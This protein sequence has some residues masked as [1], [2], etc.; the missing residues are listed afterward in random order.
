MNRPIARLSLDTLAG[1]LEDHGIGTPH[2]AL[3]PEPRYRSAS[4]NQQAR[5]QRHDELAAAGL[6]ER[7]GRVN[8]DFLDWLPLLCSAS[9]EY[10]AWFTSDDR[11]VGI[12]AARRGMVGMLATCIDDLVVLEEI[13]RFALCQ[14]LVG[15]FPEVPPGGG[16]KWSI[17]TLD[18]RR[19][20]PQGGGG[21][22]ENRL[23]RDIR[24]V[25]QVMARPVY[26]SGEL[27]VAER[28]ER[29]TYA[30][31]PEPLHYVD[32]DWGR[33]L[34]YSIGSGDDEYLCLAPAT[35]HTLTTEIEQLRRYLAPARR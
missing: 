22:M 34:N 21:V 26:G 10:Y 25:S 2:V 15:R 6:V 23:P 5:K 3:Q 13:D 11:T 33:Y 20:S 29:G 24:A 7:D 32:T 27:Y 31:L 9:L 16:T 12:L 28:D 14:T 1:V 35:P 4:E 8:R 17:R 18:V 30:T 19:A